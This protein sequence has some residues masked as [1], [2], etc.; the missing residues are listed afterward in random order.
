MDI[1]ITLSIPPRECADSDPCQS[2][3]P[4]ASPAVAANESPEEA[5]RDADGDSD[6]PE[7][8]LKPCRHVIPVVSR[9]ALDGRLAMGYGSQD[10]RG[11]KQCARVSAYKDRYRARIE[12]IAFS[13]ERNCTPDSTIIIYVDDDFADQLRLYIEYWRMN[14]WHKRDQTELAA[15]RSWERIY[16]VLPRTEVIVA[17]VS[18]IDNPAQVELREEALKWVN[19]KAMMLRPAFNRPSYMRKVN[20]M[21]RGGGFT[22]RNRKGDCCGNAHP[23]NAQCA[24]ESKMQTPPRRYRGWCPLCGFALITRVAK[25]GRYAGNCFIGCT[26]YPR[27]RFTRQMSKP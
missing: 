13:L 8:P 9:P 15:R 7:T 14:D 18:A 17:N 19:R 23:P 24:G 22:G 26:G 4:S 16:A 5:C 21:R 6:C 11:E 2:E 3:S 25:A 10:D 12:A 1:K 20:Y 27:C